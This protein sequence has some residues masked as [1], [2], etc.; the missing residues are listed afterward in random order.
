MNRNIWLPVVVVAAILGAV[1]VFA[2]NNPPKNLDEKVAEM[3]EELRDAAPTFSVS[4][5]VEVPAGTPIALTLGTTLSTKTTSVGDR[6]SAT[7]AAPVR[8]QGETAIPAGAAVAGHVIVA[9]QPGKSSGRGQLQ[10]A[11]ETLSFNG[12][13]Y[14]LGSRSQVYLSKS[15]TKKDAIMIGGGAVAGGILGRV[16]GNSTGDAAK[17][18]VVGGA[19]GTAASLLTR[20]PQL[21]LA[22]GS[23]IRFTLDRDVAVRPPSES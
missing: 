5:S 1:S 9:Q 3:R 14:P 15:G 12:R 8:V 17:G 21:T 10:L 20:G 18:A 7:V 6:F 19:A 4:R 13:N 11:F 16:L 23:T 2:L 22:S